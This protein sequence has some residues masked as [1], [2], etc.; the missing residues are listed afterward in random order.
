MVMI[1]DSNAPSAQDKPLR[2]SGEPSKCQRAKE[3]VLDLLAEKDGIPRPGGGNYNE[4]GSPMGHMGHGGGGGGGPNGMDIGV[5]R[6]GVGLVIGKGGDMIKKIQ[7][8]TGAKVQF[9]QGNLER[10]SVLF[11]MLNAALL[12]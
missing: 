7:A 9:K 4:F 3:M 8:E 11:S 10:T 1:Q 12:T 2:I 6:Q 5:P